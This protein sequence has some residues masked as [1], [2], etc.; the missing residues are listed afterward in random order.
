M[1]RGPRCMHTAVSFQYNHFNSQSRPGYDTAIGQSMKPVAQTMSVGPGPAKPSQLPQAI[2]RKRY[3]VQAQAFFPATDCFI[4][5]SFRDIIS[6]QT[7]QQ[8]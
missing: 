7:L 1:T 4:H 3:C 6:D 5:S 2:C 8:R